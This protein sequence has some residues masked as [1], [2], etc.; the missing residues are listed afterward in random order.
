VKVGQQAMAM[1]EYDEIVKVL[2]R[3]QD[4]GLNALERQYLDVDLSRLKRELGVDT[5]S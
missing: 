1:Q 3:Y 4:T 2:K 5:I